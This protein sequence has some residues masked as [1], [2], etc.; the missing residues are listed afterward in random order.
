MEFVGYHEAKRRAAGQEVK[1]MIS[2][3]LE[4]ARDV[5]VAGSVPYS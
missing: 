5:R 1:R 3:D 4:V 2:P